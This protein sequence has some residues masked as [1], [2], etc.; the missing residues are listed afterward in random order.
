MNANM[1]EHGFFDSSKLA[2]HFYSLALE[3]VR[4]EVAKEIKHSRD[5]EAFSS[6]ESVENGVGY[7]NSGKIDVL[8]KLENFIDQLSK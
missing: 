6:R 2:E 3:D 7:Y 1:S 4:K 5:S 8:V